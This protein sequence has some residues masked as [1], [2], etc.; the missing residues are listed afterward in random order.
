MFVFPARRTSH[1]RPLRAL[2]RL[3]PGGL[4]GVSGESP[5]SRLAD[6]GYMSCFGNRWLSP[7]G[8]RILGLEDAIAEL[9]E[10]DG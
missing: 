5:Q 6:A 8:L 7:D 9:E 2:L 4:G 1:R 10:S 3:V